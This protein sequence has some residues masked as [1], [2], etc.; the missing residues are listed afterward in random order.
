MKNKILVVN[1]LKVIFK[2]VSFPLIYFFSGCLG[3]FLPSYL[4]IE[5]ASPIFYILVIPSGVYSSL[6]QFTNLITKSKNTKVCKSGH[7]VNFRLYFSRNGIP[8]P[9]IFFIMFFGGW[10]LITPSQDHLL[11]RLSWIS[12][13]CWPSSPLECSCQKKR[14]KKNI[15]F[16]QAMSDLVGSEEVDYDK[17]IEA[18]FHWVLR[19]QYN[20]CTFCQLG[21]LWWCLWLKC[22]SFNFS[23]WRISFGIHRKTIRGEVFF[24]NPKLFIWYLHRNPFCYISTDIFNPV[25]N[26]VWLISFS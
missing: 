16:W 3:Y 12:F 22:T 10:R 6:F 24:Q 4:L 26:I 9:C 1:R 25:P 13:C 17:P 14:N 23:F 7:F 2:P 19:L 21:R 8:C 15:T 20:R 11:R 18:L 5:G